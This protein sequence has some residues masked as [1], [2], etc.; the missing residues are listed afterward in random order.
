MRNMRFAILMLFVVGSASCRQAQECVINRSGTVYDSGSYTV[1]FEK[2]D[3]LPPDSGNVFVDMRFGGIAYRNHTLHVMSQCSSDTLVVRV[4][5]SN[6]E[7]LRLAV[8][9]YCLSA[10]RGEGGQAKNCINMELNICSQESI[11]LYYSL[12][13]SGIR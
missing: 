4:V 7:N 3:S 11:R 8:G 10:C 13:S 9:R 1:Y 6:G 5:D 12:G 2:D